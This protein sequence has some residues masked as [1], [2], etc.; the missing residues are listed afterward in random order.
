[1]LMRPPQITK[2][3]SLVEQAKHLQDNLSQDTALHILQ[4]NDI[5]SGKEPRSSLSDGVVELTS[6]QLDYTRQ[7]RTLQHRA[8]Q[9][10]NID[11]SFHRITSGMMKNPQMRDF[12]KAIAGVM[13]T[14][15][16]KKQKH[17]S[18]MGFGDRKLTASI[19]KTSI[20]L[21]TMYLEETKLLVQEDQLYRLN[22]LPELIALQS[23]INKSGITLFPNLMI[24][25]PP[26]YTL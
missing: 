19:R 13:G 15:Q 22:F 2:P 8:S 12:N 9:G 7:Q 11:N 18:I 17:I 5:R 1:M 21:V 24:V 25:P 6:P 23:A 3:A 26:G 10:S 16:V 20:H 4:Q 14:V